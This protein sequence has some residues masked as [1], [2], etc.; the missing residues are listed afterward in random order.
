MNKQLH[1]YQIWAAD[2]KSGLLKQLEPK[3][4]DAV[5]RV[6]TV[7]KPARAAKPIQNSEDL[8]ASLLLYSYGLPIALTLDGV[9]TLPNGISTKCHT[10][11]ISSRSVDVVY[12][13]P[14]PG[15]PVRPL[16]ILPKGTAVD[17]NLNEGGALRGVLTSQDKKGFQLSVDTAYQSELGAKIRHIVGQRGAV[18]EAPVLP[19][20][21][22]ETRI[23]PTHKDCWFLDQ[24]NTLRKGTIV[25]VSQID[26]LL[27][28]SI[29][30]PL[31]A[32]II[33]RGPRR[34]EAEV[35]NIFKIGF[36]VKFGTQ[37]P[38]Q[39]FNIALKF[40]DL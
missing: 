20:I 6:D 18:I 34:Y 25:N 15:A 17:L 21:P 40:A 22:I 8:D 2:Q 14:M 11:K 7:R 36:M 13:P 27:R 4:L 26:A 12:E 19:S 9:A 29:I 3:Q 33:F 35:S 32:K 5:P 16:A 23:E 37:L 39:D 28:A 10:T 1:K 30:P 31:G 38:V 24:T